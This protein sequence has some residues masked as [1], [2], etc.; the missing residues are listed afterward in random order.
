M[1]PWN[2]VRTNTIFGVAHAAGM[3]TAWSDK[4][5]AYLSVSG[6]RTSKNVDHFFLPEINS[7]VVPLNV[8]TPVPDSLHCYPIPYP[9]QTVDYTTSFQ[10]IRCYDTVKVNAILNEIDGKDHTG[11]RSTRVPSI[12]GMNFQAVALVLTA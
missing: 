6:P 3:Y 2:F 10:N 12:F 8:T 11:T 7:A 1:Y 4:H 9:A 5:P